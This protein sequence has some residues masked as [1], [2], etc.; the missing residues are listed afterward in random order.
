MGAIPP[1]PEEPPLLER[2]DALLADPAQRDNP[3]RAPLAQLHA[4]FLDQ[5]RQLDRITRI[6]D[7]YQAAE[8]ERGHGYAL[9]Y[10]QQLRRLEKI[11]RISDR[12]Q[13]LLRELNQRLEWLSNRD[14]LTGLPNRRN[15]LARMHEE[16]LRSQRT[17]KPFALAI[18][19]IDHFKDINDTFGHE[20]GDRVLAAVAAT[21][22]SSVREYDLC[23]RWGGEEFLVLLPE[24]DAAGAYESATRL[25]ASIAGPVQVDGHEIPVTVSL[26]AGSSEPGEDLAQLMKRV[27]EALYRAK[28]SGRNRFELASPARSATPGFDIPQLSG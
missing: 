27:D 26:G 5:I 6:S 1:L 28:R 12:Y 20:A 8:R 17:G 18:A 10:R 25:C 11:V 19:D 15:A 2:I 4:T 3:L 22:A 7:H 23:A 9:N 13:G 21:L 24:I 14:P 16:Q